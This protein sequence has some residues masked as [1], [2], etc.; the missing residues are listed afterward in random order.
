V[1]STISST[2]TAPPGKRRLR[3]VRRSRPRL[4][5][6][7]QWRLTA[8]VAAVLLVAAGAVLVVVYQETG[9]QLR[10]QIDS[11][12]TGDVNQ[13]AQ[14]VGAINAKDPAEFV[15]PVQRYVDSQG[16]SASSRLLFATIPG[17]P[18]ISNH[19]E[20][21]GKVAREHGESLAEQQREGADGRKLLG[22]APGFSVHT[23]ADAGSVRVD[24][25][26]VTVA[27]VR[28]LVGA[29]EAL[30]LVERAQNGVARTFLFAG[31][32]ILLIALIASYLAGAHVSAPLR[33]MA[34][35]AARVDAGELAPR[36]E[37]DGSRAGEIQVLAESFNT[38]LDRLSEAFV[39][40]REFV[41]DASH[42]LRT[43]LTVI[44]GQLEVL[45]ADA[46][47]SAAEVQRVEHLVQAEVSRISRLVDDL[48]LLAQSERMDFL[49]VQSVELE[50]FITDL[51]EGLSHTA[52]RRF[53]LGPVPSGTLQADPDRLAQAVRNL[54]RNAIEH[55]APGTGQV[56]LEVQR[57]SEQTVRLSV[58]DN[59]PGIPAPERERVF[60]RFHRTDTSRARAQGG[61]GLGLAIVQA[62][63]EAH[64][65][66][67]RA[68]SANGSAGARLELTL[69]R[70]RPA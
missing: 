42:E 18:T 54:V 16:Y 45:A 50:P 61:T 20:V 35:V 12:I 26:V 32:L 7:L 47:P 51:W 46:E 57:A 64:G 60:E 52:D 53:E 13:L 14:A 68:V 66:Q 39:A 36:M 41:A 59:G 24:M 23:L 8:W 22:S 21:F 49:R 62:I 17:Y 29:G 69:P 25:R 19:P 55:T 10:A 44:R 43:P 40:Q 1:E 9:E 15:G 6:G 58:V 38:M 28:V 3:A 65:G 2:E 70:F 33:Q 34:L 67:A 5:R 56:R 31:A 11:E 27:G 30:A 37:T 63:V 48:L 4:P